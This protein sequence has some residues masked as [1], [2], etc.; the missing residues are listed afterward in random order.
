MQSGGFVMTL[1]VGFLSLHG[2]KSQG[3]LNK[4]IDARRGGPCE[5]ESD[6]LVNDFY[7]FKY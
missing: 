5:L 7:F 3:D 6:Y 4:A 1:N 2:N